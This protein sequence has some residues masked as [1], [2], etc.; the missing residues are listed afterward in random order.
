MRMTGRRV[1]GVLAPGNERIVLLI[2]KLFVF[3][4]N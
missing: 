2:S 1:K 4:Y 3:N